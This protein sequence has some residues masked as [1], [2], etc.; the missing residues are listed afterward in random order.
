MMITPATMNVKTE[1]EGNLLVNSKIREQIRRAGVRH[2]AV[3]DAMGISEDT[4]VRWLRKPL[5]EEKEKKVLEGVRKA[6][7]RNE[8]ER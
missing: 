4:L 2:W 7:E 8:R 3:A 1:T 6:R 5:T